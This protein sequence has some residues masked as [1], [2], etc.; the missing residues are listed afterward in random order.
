MKDELP[1]VGDEIYIPTSLY[2]GHGE[3]DVLGGLATI[4]KVKLNMKC[5]NEFNRIFVDINEVNGHSYNWK[6]L[7]KNQEKY[8]EMY[9]DKIACFVNK[10]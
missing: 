8:K 2:I 6:F 4:S 9:G 10:Y 1:K 5:S 7:M 3:D